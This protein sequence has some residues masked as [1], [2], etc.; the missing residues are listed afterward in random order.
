MN[1]KYESDAPYPKPQ[2]ENKNIHYAELLL[3]DYAGAVSEQTAVHLYIYQSMI[4][5]PLIPNFN[6]IL[7]RIAITEMK[8]F[9]LLGET[10]N[11]LGMNPMY[12]VVDAKDGCFVPWTASYVLDTQLIEEMLIAD[13]EAEAKAI[14]D[15]QLHICMIDDIYIKALLNRIIEDEKLHLEIFQSL[16]QELNQK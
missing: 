16:Y 5:T 9:K 7:E 6:H 3:Q 13:I 10:I 11:L 15:Y 14:L 1:L 12:H 2:V 4:G 8:H